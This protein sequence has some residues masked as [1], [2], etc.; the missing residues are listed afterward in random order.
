MYGV[1]ADGE[2]AARR[3]C[4][5][6]HQELGAKYDD[7]VGEDDEGRDCNGSSARQIRHA[8]SG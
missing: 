8:A 4:D 1:S 2:D 5:E 3:R 6:F 7:G